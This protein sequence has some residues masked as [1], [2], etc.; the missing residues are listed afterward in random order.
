V[1]EGG[2]PRL[3][4][5]IVVQDGAD[6]DEF[7]ARLAFPSAQ[8][9]LQR[10]EAGFHTS[11]WSE[12]GGRSNASG[13]VTFGGFDAFTT[14][15]GGMADVCR[16]YFDFVGTPALV[17]GLALSNFVDDFV[18][19][20][21]GTVTSIDAPVRASHRLHQNYPNPFNPTTQIP[22]HV[23]ADTGEKLHVRIAVYDVRGALVRTLV[24]AERAPGS[25]VAAWDG[26]ADNGAHAASGIYFY[27][28]RVGDF[29]ASRR[30]VLLK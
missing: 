20:T 12:V 24:D 13:Q 6:L 19:A 18:G 27:S 8:L 1:S 5:R 16:I 15:S 22:Y 29:A 4:V 25:Y 17:A 23:A 21:V 26:R 2:T 7:G 28:M 30:M 11:G 3:E 14:T 10:V 9:T